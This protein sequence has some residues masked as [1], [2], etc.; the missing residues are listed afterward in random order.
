MKVAI[1]MSGGVDSS[2]AAALLKEAG[3][4]VVGVTMRLMP[5]DSR[6]ET[7][8]ANIARRLGITHYVIDLTHIFAERVIEDFC[9]EYSRGRTP[10]PCVQCNKH[11]KFGALMEKTREL[12][13]DFIATGHHTRTER[14]ENTGKYLLM[15]GADRQRDQSY[16][17]CRL[18]QKQL[19]RAVF[20]VGH[21]TK[22]KVRQIAGELGLPVADRPESREIC[23]IPDDDY[24]GFLNENVPQASRPGPI[25]DN[26]GKL[27]GEHRGLV[28]YTVGQRRGLGI[29]A[30]APLY[31]I[32]IDPEKNAIIA[33]AKEETY[34]T[35]LVAGSL[36]WIAIAKPESAIKV[37]AS[38]RYRHA[39][40]ET[41]V[42][43][44]ENGSVYVKFA[45]PQSAIAPGQTIVFYEGDRVIGGGTITRHGK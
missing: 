4:E 45:E 30:D 15:K 36:N 16:F 5:R 29:A 22:K 37:K 44:L 3:H 40:A 35:E 8:A 2:V 24:A 42:N 38:I 39:E 17:L 25:L 41:V 23:F 10:N 6:A 32:A 18:D 34:G 9:R 11:I 14:D 12:G 28:H 21:L 20:P 1:A 26:Q 33:G 43:P 13:A 31:V 19:S 7:D 27:L